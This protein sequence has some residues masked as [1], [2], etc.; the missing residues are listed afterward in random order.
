VEA[1]IHRA[2]QASSRLRI[3]ALFP[4]Q[5][6]RSCFI[7]GGN[8]LL[9][10]AL[11]FLPLSLNYNWVYL[12]A[13]PPFQLNEEARAS[14]DNALQL[15]ARAKAEANA[16]VITRLENL[17]NDLE[18][19]N[20]SISEAIQQLEELQQELEAG[21]LDAENMTNG[22]GQMA[23]ILRQAKVL[24][25]AALPMG[26]GKLAEAAA[27][28]RKVR[29]NLGGVSP[30]DSRE[31]S[32]KLLSASENPRSGLQELASAFEAAGNALETGDREAARTGFERISKELESL[33]ERLADQGLRSEAGDEIE[34]L[35]EALE[36]DELESGESD[37]PKPGQTGS[38][39][40]MAEPQANAAGEGGE[41]GEGENG[42]PE[43]F[44][45]GEP[46]EGEPGEGEAG[47][48][49]Q[50]DS[51]MAN[52][53]GGNSFGGSTKSA[54]LEGEATSL[55]VQ[56]QKEALQIELAEGTQEPEQ[57]IESA[58]ERER[59][60]LDYRNAPSNLTPAQKDLL[61]QDRIPW[62]SRQLIKN[63][64][65]AVKP[66]Q[67]PSNNQ[68]KGFRNCSRG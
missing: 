37:E 53:R 17:I 15:L 7:V 29:D 41:P 6:P 42:L 18:E 51:D 34:D 9:L 49:Q 68:L 46:G 61:S 20:I 31:M 33:G 54:P 44:A 67:K 64:F 5:L 52:G 14:L 36:T 28:M 3:E 30:A 48:N 2:A 38:N 27:L 40:G 65:Q 56:L 11:N 47:D 16:E 12:H 55:E 4:R 26:Q 25:D 13:A 57:D 19:G 39:Q 59:S 23:S 8:L 1:L 10:V 50:G 35:V 62:E 32:E 45:E 66:A 43:E 58:G 60:K 21:E 24:R 22:L 63:Y